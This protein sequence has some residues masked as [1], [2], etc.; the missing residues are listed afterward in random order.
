ME[1][2]PISK[3]LCFVVFRIMDDGQSPDVVGASNE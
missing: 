2:D 1:T 3:T